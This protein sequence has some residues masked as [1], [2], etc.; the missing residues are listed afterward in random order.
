[1]SDKKDLLKDSEVE[2]VSA[3]WVINANK[4]VALNGVEYDGAYT[5]I[6]EIENKHDKS[7]T[8]GHRW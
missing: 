3:G 7:S 6:W 2:N 8:P 1:M 5:P 4:K